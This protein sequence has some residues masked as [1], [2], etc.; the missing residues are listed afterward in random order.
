P[1]DQA[2]YVE[3]HCEG[4]RVCKVALEEARKR[5][6]AM[7]TLPPREASEALIQ[8]TLARVDTHE[9]QR[10]R[11]RRLLAR[12]LFLGFAACWLALLGGHLYVNNLSA[13]PYDLSVYGQTDLLAGTPGSLRVRLIDHRNGQALAGVPVTIELH[14]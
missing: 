8:S 6:T 10:R 2:D 9:R 13:S 7:E 3:R 14:G 12:G 11:F 5:F 4:C 1:P